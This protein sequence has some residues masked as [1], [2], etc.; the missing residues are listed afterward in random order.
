MTVLL[1]LADGT[2]IV[3]ESVWDNRFK[4]VDQLLRMGANISVEG[5]VAIVQGVEQLKGAPVGADD[6]RAGAAMLIAGFAA[7][8]Q[9]EIENISHIDR[10]YERFVEKFTALGGDIKRVEF[11]DDDETATE[12]AG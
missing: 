3:S 11:P 1:A 12:N 2:S 4:Y 9:T 8:G 6:L 10:G 5:K 7:H